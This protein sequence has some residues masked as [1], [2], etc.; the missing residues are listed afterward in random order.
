MGLIKAVE[1]S[2]LVK[3]L[4]FQHMQLGGL[5][6]QLQERLL[7]KHVQSVFLSIWLKRLIN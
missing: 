3:G 1:N 6:R 7:T 5:D 2:T 4:N